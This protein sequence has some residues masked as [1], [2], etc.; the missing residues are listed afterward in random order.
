MMNFAL[1]TSKSSIQKTT[2]DKQAFYQLII[3][4]LHKQF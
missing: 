4:S 2:A 1:Q 3:I